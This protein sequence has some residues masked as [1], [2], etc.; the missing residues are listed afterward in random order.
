MKIRYKATE[1]RIKIAGLSPF[2]FS[3][4]TL[5]YFTTFYIVSGQKTVIAVV[6]H[7]SEDFE[8]FIRTI[9]FL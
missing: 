4:D 2:S 5:V 3:D 9:R 6:N 1:S 7:E 8:Y